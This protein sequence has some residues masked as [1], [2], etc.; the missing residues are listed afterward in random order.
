MC[1]FS[2]PIELVANT[3]IFARSS[4]RDQF[5]V[6]SMT[7]ASFFPVAMVL[8]LPVPANPPEDA[9][10][11]I[12]LERY[13]RFFD[14]M[15]SGFPPRMAYT[16]SAGSRAVVIDAPKLK[17]HSVGSY[18]ASFVPRLADFDRLDERFRIP[19]EVWDR[20][21]EY[22][23]YGFAVFKPQRDRR[24][25][26]VCVCSWTLYQRASTERR[27]PNGTCVSAQEFGCALFSYRPRAR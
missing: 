21:P 16:R 2:Q 26:F 27:S 5:L 22:L 12:N 18:E 17:V 1:C 15:R 13:P 20:L 4:N 7:Y 8:P 24:T 25:R 23:D 3:S 11:F 6:Y 9:V 14:D 19:N 10:R